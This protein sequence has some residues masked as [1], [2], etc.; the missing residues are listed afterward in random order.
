MEMALVALSARWGL[1]PARAA[2][3]RAR[4]IIEWLIG[5]RFARWRGAG[6]LDVY[7]AARAVSP[8]AAQAARGHLLPPRQALGRPR[9]GAGGLGR[10]HDPA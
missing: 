10:G 7:V 4:R 5:F 8:P 3:A 9:R 6:D 1:A 2:T